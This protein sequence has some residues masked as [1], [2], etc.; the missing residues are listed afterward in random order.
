MTAHSEHLSFIN[1]EF[2]TLFQIKK[3]AS[4]GFDMQIR[5][6]R[7]SNLL[8]PLSLKKLGHQD[9]ALMLQRT[10]ADFRFGMKHLCAKL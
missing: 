5:S 9:T 10:L 7:I 1:F 3:F 8:I 4:L 6:Q 2:P